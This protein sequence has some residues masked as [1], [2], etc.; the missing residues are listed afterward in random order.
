LI[1]AVDCGVSLGEVCDI[2]RE[3]FGVYTDPGL[4]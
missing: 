3:V 4:V 2:F 1:E